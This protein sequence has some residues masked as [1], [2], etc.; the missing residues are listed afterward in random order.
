[1]EH[2]ES[3]TLDE[4]SPMAW[5]LLR[6]AAGYEQRVVEREVEDL[7]QAHISMLEN[8]NRALSNSR[9][10]ELFDL[11]TEELTAEQHRAIINN[12]E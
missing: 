6:V 7:M 1:M 8:G 11:Y 3:L 12:F 2:T 5:R 10:R 9:R 4:I